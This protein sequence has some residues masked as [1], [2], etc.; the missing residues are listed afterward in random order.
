[1]GKFDQ[2]N[3]W[4]NGVIKNKSI[5]K[6]PN[7]GT[8]KLVYYQI[9]NGEFDE[10]PFWKM[11]EMELEKLQEEIII[12]RQNNRRASEEAFEDWVMNRRKVYNKKIQKQREEHQRF[13]EQCLRNLEKALNKAFKFEVSPIDIEAFEGSLTELYFAYK[14]HLK[15]FI[16]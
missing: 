9:L 10:S 14:Y 2:F 3:Y 4:R 8:E 13:E 1:M 6:V 15:N 12:W 11:S 16:P 5:K 7:G